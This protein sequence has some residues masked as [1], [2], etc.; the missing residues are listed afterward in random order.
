MFR[1]LVNSLPEWAAVLFIIAG[2]LLFTF[3]LTALVKYFK[4][5]FIVE[6]RAITIFA[7]VSGTFYAVLLGFTIIA[8][9]QAITETKNLVADEATSLSSI[10][11]F[12][13]TFP[14][15][16]RI[17]ILRAVKNYVDLVVN[18]EWPAMKEGKDSE[19]TWDAFN[20]LFATIVALE[21]EGQVQIIRYSEL[22]NVAD[23]ALQ[24][25]RQRLGHID[26]LV[27]G[28]MRYLLTAGAALLMFCLVLIAVGSN[29]MTTL[30][31]Y[32]VAA[33][34]AFVFS[35]VVVFGYPFSGDRAV[36]SRPF[37]AGA[38][39][40][41]PRLTASLPPLSEEEK[42]EDVFAPVHTSKPT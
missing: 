42:Q 23:K 24:T 12:S 40:H 41:L 35:F 21:P 38:L 14:E 28:S 8:L 25:R 36:S 19:Q 5:H 3:C 7:N 13:R 29:K 9:W 33:F 26:S 1:E 22:L 10:V 2:A 17:A 6:P 30:L 18:E 16:D 27:T 15:K 39:K 31:V 32:V 4:S 20:Y 37:T 11:R 34:L